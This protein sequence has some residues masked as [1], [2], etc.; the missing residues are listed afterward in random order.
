M[1]Q[2]KFSHNFSDIEKC[3]HWYSIDTY[4]AQ[5]R[6]KHAHHLI[7]ESYGLSAGKAYLSIKCKLF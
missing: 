4:A 5:C 1:L 3:F 2:E 6:Q 7:Q